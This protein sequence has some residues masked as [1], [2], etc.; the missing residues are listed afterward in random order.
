[1]S[2]SESEVRA[3][4]LTWD[5]YQK[6]SKKE[7][8]FGWGVAFQICGFCVRVK[9]AVRGER[10]CG[11][12]KVPIGRTLSAAACEM[13]AALNWPARCGVTLDDERESVTSLSS[14]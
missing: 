7:K 13:S 4:Y 5:T 3:F 8:A 9:L 10:C 6:R 12:G 1:M 14:P 2:E 11:E